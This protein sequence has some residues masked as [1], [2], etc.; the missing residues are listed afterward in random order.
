MNHLTL[1]P[2]YGRDYRSKAGVLDDWKAGKDFRSVG[3]H[4]TGYINRADVEKIS[5]PVDV[6]IRYQ[7]LSRVLVIPAG[8]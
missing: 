4:G 1:T 5:P 2:A 6:N 3:I 7:K 8:K